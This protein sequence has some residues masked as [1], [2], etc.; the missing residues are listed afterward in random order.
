MQP[1][2]FD[3]D[4]AQA[5]AVAPPPEDAGGGMFGKMKQAMAMAQHLQALLRNGF[6]ERYYVA[7]SKVRVDRSPSRKRRSSIALPAR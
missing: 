1:G 4:Y 3:Q 5:A 7:G 6:A 2:S